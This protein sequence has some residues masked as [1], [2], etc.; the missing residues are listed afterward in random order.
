MKTAKNKKAVICASIVI[1]AGVF[2]YSFAIWLKVINY[3][4]DK[5]II[6]QDI[7]LKIFLHEIN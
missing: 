4:N 2:L 6:C 1:Q 7:T 5:L 3:I